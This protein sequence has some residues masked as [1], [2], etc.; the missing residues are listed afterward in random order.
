[1]FTACGLSDLNP[2]LG[3]YYSVQV[4]RGHEFPQQAHIVPTSYPHRVEEMGTW[5]PR[6]NA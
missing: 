6:V 1:M 5:A 4:N 3:P 2:L